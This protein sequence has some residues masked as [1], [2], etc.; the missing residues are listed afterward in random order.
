M[1]EPR[2]LC[3][4]CNTRTVS[5]LRND[6]PGFTVCQCSNCHEIKRECPWCGQDW[7]AHYIV[8]EEPRS[9][10]ICDSCSSTWD[11]SWNKLTLDEG[12]YSLQEITGSNPVRVRDI[13]KRL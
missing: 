3:E 5:F 1:T 11:G 2:G 7:L 9:R 12:T 13:E 8:D 4:T 10:Y 6:P